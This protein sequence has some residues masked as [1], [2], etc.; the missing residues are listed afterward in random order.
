LFEFTWTLPPI[1]IDQYCK[2]IKRFI[3]TP[4]R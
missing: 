2:S 4:L 3:L 1:V